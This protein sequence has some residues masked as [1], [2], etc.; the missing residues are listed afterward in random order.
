M[1]MNPVSTADEWAMLPDGSVAVLRSDT[2]SIEWI[3]PD[4]TRDTTPPIPGR[5]RP[6]PLTEKLTL[7]ENLRRAATASS[8][9]VRVDVDPPEAVAD[10]Q[11][12]FVGSV[13]ADPDGRLWVRPFASDYS[14]QVAYDIIDS[15]GRLVERALLPAGRTIV[16]IG[17]GV[18]YAQRFVQG[19]TVLERIPVR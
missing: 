6:I 11:P 7:I 1:Y 16:G 15:R 9:V 8:S 3:R 14:P 17:R 5:R 2:Y 19:A 13:F 12:A 18:V 4:G 10:F